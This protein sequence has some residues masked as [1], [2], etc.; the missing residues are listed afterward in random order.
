MMRNVQ[1]ALVALLTLVAC[2]SPRPTEYI[3]V[4]FTPSVDTDDYRTWDF[5]L[6]SCSDIGD[7]RFDDDFIREKMLA[8]IQAALGERGYEHRPGGPVDFTVYYELWLADG[9]DLAGVE[10]RVR[11]KIL[12]RDVATGRLV[13]RGE[14]KAPT[15]PGSTPGQLAETVRAFVEDLLQYTRKLE[16]PEEQEG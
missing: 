2:H 7:P 13:W 5:E 16:E 1:L 3:N 8:A 15:R 10:E 11:G 9:G 6:D 12:V 14:R 4:A